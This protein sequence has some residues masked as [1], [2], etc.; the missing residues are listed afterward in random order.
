MKLGKLFEDL[1]QLENQLEMH[2]KYKLSQ[3]NIRDAFRC[4]DRQGR[5]FATLEDY[6]NFFED[7]YSEDLPVSTEE[8]DYLFKRQDKEALGR[9]TEAVFLKE[10]MP[11]DDYIMID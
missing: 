4:I 3:I 7:F 2:R 11:L 1:L 6:Y 9:V 5:G 10:L 8:I